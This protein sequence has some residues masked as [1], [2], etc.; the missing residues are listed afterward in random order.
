M[1]SSFA[2]SSGR[3][4]RFTFYS[5]FAVVVSLS[6]LGGSGSFSDLLL[7]GGGSLTLLGFLL[8]YL[9]ESPTESSDR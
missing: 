8:L 6:A 9:Q 1:L 4:G 7:Y 5:S 3:S 2:F